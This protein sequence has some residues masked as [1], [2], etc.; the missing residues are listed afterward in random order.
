MKWPKGFCTFGGGG[1]GGVQRK[2]GI[3]EW[4]SQQPQ[5]T[6]AGQWRWAGDAVAVLAVVPSSFSFPPTVLATRRVSFFRSRSV[7]QNCSFDDPRKR[8]P[9]TRHQVSHRLRELLHCVG[10]VMELS[11]TEL[12]GLVKRVHSRKLTMEMELFLL[13]V[14]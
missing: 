12:H 10:L 5:Q 7:A 4:S 11:S 6:M 14:L 9:S 1:A 3:P 13:Q 2:C 8:P